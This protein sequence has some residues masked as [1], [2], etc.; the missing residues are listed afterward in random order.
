MV[1]LAGRGL[2]DAGFSAARRS[3]ADGASALRPISYVHKSSNGGASVR[4]A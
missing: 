1:L 3:T 4:Q 2:K